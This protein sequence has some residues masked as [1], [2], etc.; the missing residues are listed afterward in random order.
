MCS[1]AS[2][3]PRR[4]TSINSPRRLLLVVKAAQV[5]LLPALLDAS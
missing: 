5:L 1:L 4:L 2:Q 3:P